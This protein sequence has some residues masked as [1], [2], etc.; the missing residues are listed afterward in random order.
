MLFG[1][2]PG[3]KMA[4]TIMPSSPDYN[5]AVELPTSLEAFQRAHGAIRCRDNAM[6]FQSSPAEPICVCTATLTNIDANT[7]SATVSWRMADYATTDDV[8]C[9]ICRCGRFTTVEDR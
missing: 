2:Q 1:A 3:E 7:F 6:A 8:R 4:G 5:N 9:S